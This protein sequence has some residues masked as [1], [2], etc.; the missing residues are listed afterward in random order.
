VPQ[1]GD[2]ALRRTDPID[3]ETRCVAAARGLDVPQGKRQGR[4]VH[5]EQS[6]IA[7]RTTAPV[8][9]LGYGGKESRE[10]VRTAR[11]WIG[12]SP[13]PSKI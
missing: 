4:F 11:L 5:L 7:E 1:P 2:A 6:D 10:Q 12:R 3:R 9:A 8:R 13:A